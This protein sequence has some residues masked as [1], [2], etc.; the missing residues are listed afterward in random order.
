[1]TANSDSHYDAPTIAQIS[2]GTPPIKQKLINRDIV[3]KYSVVAFT[4]NTKANTRYHVEVTRLESYDDFQYRFFSEGMA[5]A[6][7][8]RQIKMLRE[9]PEAELPESMDNIAD[10]LIRMPDVREVQ[11]TYNNCGI[12][13]VK[14]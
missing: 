10:S 8:V 11:V 9:D 7:Y 3:S 13:L 5:V 4:Y 2:K 6:E 1:M 12:K 14:P